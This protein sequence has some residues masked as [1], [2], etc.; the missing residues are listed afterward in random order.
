MVILSN[1]M[2]LGQVEIPFIFQKR[3]RTSFIDTNVK[4]VRS[5]FKNILKN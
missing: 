1:E 3:W 5:A 2:H 4:L